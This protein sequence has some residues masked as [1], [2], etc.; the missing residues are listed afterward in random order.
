LA[1][2]EVEVPQNSA[3]VERIV[4]IARK[5]FA[6]PRYQP[7]IRAAMYSRLGRSFAARYLS[8]LTVLDRRVAGERIMKLYRSSKAKAKFVDT[9]RRFHAKRPR[10]IARFDAYAIALVNSEMRDEAIRVLSSDRAREL[11]EDA[12]GDHNLYGLQIALNAELARYRDVVE[13]GRASLRREGRSAP[14]AV[15]HDYLKAAFAAGKS[16]RETDAIEFFG[17]QYDGSLRHKG[18]ATPVEI[19]RVL[20]SY[21]DKVSYT[22]EQNLRLK[23]NLGDDKTRYAVFFLS[24]TEALGHAILDPYYFIAQ[25]RDRADKLIFIGPSRDN[26]RPASRACLQMVEQYGEYVETGSD[27]LLNLSW[28]SLGHHTVGNFTFVV[29]NYWA[30]LRNAVHR[31]REAKDN[32]RHNQWFLELPE[33]YDEIGRDFCRR[34]KIDLAKPLVVMHVRDKGYHGIEKQSFRDSS[35]ENYRE[36]VD[37]MLDQGLQV[38]RI[39]DTKMPEL[40]IDR[41]GY[42]ELPRMKGYSHELDPFLI[43]KSL[44]MIGCQSGPC[45]FARALGVPILTINA[46][47]HYTLLPSSIEMGCFKRYVVEK[48]G[49]KKEIDL[50]QALDLGVYHFDITHQFEKAGVT[51]VDASPEEIVASVKDMMAWVANRDL[52]ETPDQ[53]ALRD[54]I[55]A[56]A[57]DL[58]ARGRDLSLPIAD[59]IGICLPGYRVSPSVLEMRKTIPWDPTKPVVK[60]PAPPAKSNEKVKKTKERARAES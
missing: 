3:R 43:S 15:R 25:N 23:R 18:K 55:E 42:C 48:D 4:R 24:S 45:S 7:L 32:Y 36:A 12:K 11:I 57:Q 1:E 49:V 35:V 53:I 5:L 40:E 46:V 51:V 47:L 30:L 6:N 59:Y 56:V 38:I 9:A 10:N 34:H 50:H 52:T 37:H 41:N 39:G 17:R 29:D 21:Q 20:R 19:D 44:F 13:W 31:T 27:E 22:L 16:R 33:Y 2:D 58:K 14:L 54:K 60:R 8:G 26:Y 28:M